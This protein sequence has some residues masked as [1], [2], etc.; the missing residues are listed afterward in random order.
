MG[1]MNQ[2]KIQYKLYFEDNLIITEIKQGGNCGR[3]K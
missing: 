2:S 3:E 1:K